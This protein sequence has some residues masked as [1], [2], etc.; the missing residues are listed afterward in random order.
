MTKPRKVKLPVVENQP[1]IEP[2]LKMAIQKKTRNI[3]P[4]SLAA[5]GIYL[6]FRVGTALYIYIYTYN[7]LKY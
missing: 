1:Q 4:K 5:K 3:L 2:T 6:I 7:V